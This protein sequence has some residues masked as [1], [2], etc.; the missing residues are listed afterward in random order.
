MLRV[1]RYAARW[2]L[3]LQSYSVVIADQEL[4]EGSNQLNKEPILVEIQVNRD[5]ST[6]SHR[7]RYGPSGKEA[8]VLLG[9][10]PFVM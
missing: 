10:T 2:S 8:A 9:A 5:V 3:K 1:A 4:V 6:Q 7:C